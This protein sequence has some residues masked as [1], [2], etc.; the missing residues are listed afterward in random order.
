MNQTGYEVESIGYD[1]KVFQGLLES[2]F[3]PIE[4]NIEEEN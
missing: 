4:E 2:G 1:E 3:M